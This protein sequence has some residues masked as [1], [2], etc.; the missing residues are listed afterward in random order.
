MLFLEM[1]HESH[2]INGNP[3]HPRRRPGGLVDH[4]V[5]DDGWIPDNVAPNLLGWGIW[6]NEG[7]EDNACHGGWDAERIVCRT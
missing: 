4:D 5:D 3:H 7:L 1:N 2:T 6:N